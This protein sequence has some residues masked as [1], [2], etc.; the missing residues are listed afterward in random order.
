MVSLNEGGRRA[1]SLLETL[2][3]NQFF[4]FSSFQGRLH[5]LAHGTFFH[6]PGQQH[7]IFQPLSASIITLPSSFCCE[8]SLWLPLVKTLEHLGPSW[9]TQIISPSQGS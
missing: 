8:I 4:V 1:V 9:I 6:L 2:G 3:E 5:S 7:S